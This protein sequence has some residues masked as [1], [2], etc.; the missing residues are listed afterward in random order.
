MADKEKIYKKYRMIFFI[1]YIVIAL[2]LFLV[3][4]LRVFEIIPY[5]ERRLLIYNIITLIGVAYIIFDLWW[6]L[7]KSKRANFSLVDK[8]PPAILAIFLLTFDILVLAKVVVDPLFIKYS[9]FGVLMYAGTYALCMG[10]YHFNK[11]QKAVLDAVEEAY[12]AALQEE[13]EEAKKQEENNNE[14]K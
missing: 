11:P 6:N 10:I 9:I 8:I 1:E 7:R 14:D 3:G 4:F 2:V 12:Q 13:A 5:S